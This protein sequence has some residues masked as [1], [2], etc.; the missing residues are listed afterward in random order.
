MS[1]VWWE[2]SEMAAELGVFVPKAVVGVRIA[3]DDPL[4][5]EP[6]QRRHEI[7]RERLEQHFVSGT[8]NAFAGRGLGRAQNADAHLCRPHDG[9]KRARYLPT[10]G[11]ERLCRA[12][13]E[14]PVESLS[15]R[16]RW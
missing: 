1:W 10:P 5:S 6:V 12:D 8:P 14:Q 2:T 4:H 3:G 11:I 16:P 7:L 13:V 15:R 9:D